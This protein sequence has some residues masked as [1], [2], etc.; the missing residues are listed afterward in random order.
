VAKKKYQKEGHPISAF[1][2]RFAVF[3]FRSPDG[4]SVC[5]GRQAQSIALPFG[6]MVK[7]LRCSDALKRKIKST[8]N[9]K[10]PSKFPVNDA[11]YHR[12]I[13]LG[14]RAKPG[15][16]ARVE[17]QGCAFDAIPVAFE[18]R[19]TSVI[20]GRVFFRPF[21]CRVTKKWTRYSSEAAGEIDF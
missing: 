1:T 2:L 11:E 4:T 14:R 18:K 5:R 19:R 12:T 15:W 7:A 21:L 16:R 8:G 3:P 6:L 20:L 17:A 10:A 13:Q 9:V